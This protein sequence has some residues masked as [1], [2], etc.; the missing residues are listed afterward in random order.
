MQDREGQRK[1][2]EFRLLLALQV[3]TDPDMIDRME[4]ERVG[5][6]GFIWNDTV[7]KELFTDSVR[8]FCIVSRN[9]RI[10]DLTK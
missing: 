6:R 7:V 2:W 10:G 8:A 9:R 4:P 1:A 5:E 3:G